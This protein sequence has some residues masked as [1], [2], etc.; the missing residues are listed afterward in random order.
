MSTTQ[1]SFTLVAVTSRDGYITG[2]DGEPPHLWASPEEQVRFAETVSALDWSFIGRLTHTIAWRPQRRRVVFSRSFRTPVWRHPCRLWV[3]P[4]RVRLATILD[5]LR[6][7]HPPEHCGILGGVGVHDW[8]AERR[9]IDAADLTIEP[10]AFGRGRPLFSRMDTAE[11]RAAMRALGLVETAVV[12]L[13]AQGTRLHRFARA[14]CRQ[15][16]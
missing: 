16:A 11:P 3:D 9:L 14:A 1:P 2:P 6:P 8:F 5:A 12:T 7:V 4:A 13:N 15:H 10:F